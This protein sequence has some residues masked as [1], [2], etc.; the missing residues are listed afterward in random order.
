MQTSPEPRDATDSERV[1]L[2]TNKIAEAN[3]AMTKAKESDDFD[4]AKACKLEVRAARKS[5]SKF[6][7]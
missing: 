4:K 2:L 5:A 6:E 3:A 7:A 1:T